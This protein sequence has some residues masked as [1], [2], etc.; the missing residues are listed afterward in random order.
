MRM[1]FAVLVLALTAALGGS[2]AR[3]DTDECKEALEQYDT[4]HKAV[5]E[6]LHR[7]GR[8]VADS[9]GHDDCA[10]EFSDLQSAQDDFAA[11]VAGYGSDC[12]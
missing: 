5:T 6:A 1:V 11:A 12:S 10:T 3:S 2:A 8:C 7:Y 9:K 4:A